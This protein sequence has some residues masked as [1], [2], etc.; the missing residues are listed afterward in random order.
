MCPIRMKEGE[1]KAL[2]DATCNLQVPICKATWGCRFKTSR[3]NPKK[4]INNRM[5]G[6][7]RMTCGRREEK[8]CALSRR[9]NWG[10]TTLC[11]SLSPPYLEGFPPGAKKDLGQVRAPLANQSGRI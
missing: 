1:K 7:E 8:S 11:V 10:I 4:R 5:G 6:C 3:T 9:L 2:T